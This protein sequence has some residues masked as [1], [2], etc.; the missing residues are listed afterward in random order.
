MPITAPM[1]SQAIG[2]R[3]REPAMIAVT[4]AQTAQANAPI[5]IIEA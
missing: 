4:T 5:H 3:S 2:F 1:P